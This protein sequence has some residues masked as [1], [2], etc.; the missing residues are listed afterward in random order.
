M[1][2]A[3]NVTVTNLNISCC[4][5]VPFHRGTSSLYFR[6]VQIFG[7]AK[8]SRSVQISIMSRFCLRQISLQIYHQVK[9]YGSV[10]IAK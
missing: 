8:V 7:T 10:L 1:K 6:E 4:R 2:P 9:S 3:Y 5:Q